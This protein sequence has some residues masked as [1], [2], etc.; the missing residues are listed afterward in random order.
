MKIDIPGLGNLEILHL[1]FDLNGTLGVNGIIS[2]DVKNMVIQASKEFKVHILTSDTFN[3]IHSQV[4]GL[5]LELLIIDGSKAAEKKLSFIQGLDE[6]KVV[7][8]GNG[9]NDALM[10]QAAA[11]GIVIVGQEGASREALLSADLVF[12]DIKNAIEAVLNPKKLIAGL[13]G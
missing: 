5:S 3:T 9:R 1:V 2:D 7:A 12:Y 8:F 6:K 10:L 13:R 4:D 11:I